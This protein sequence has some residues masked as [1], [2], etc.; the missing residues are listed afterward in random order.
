MWA[1]RVGEQ[2]KDLYQVRTTDQSITVVKTSVTQ[3]II[4]DS[5]HLF[6]LRCRRRGEGNDYACHAGYH[7]YEVKIK[8]DIRDFAP[9]APPR[10][11]FC[12]V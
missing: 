6:S 11:S 10:L 8:P 3:K 4:S 12:L 5:R 1:D 2:F 9:P 7:L